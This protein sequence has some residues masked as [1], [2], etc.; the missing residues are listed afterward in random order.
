MSCLRDIVVKKELLHISISNISSG[1][2]SK[3]REKKCFWPPG[4][5]K[6]KRNEIWWE[7]FLRSSYFI[8]FLFWISNHY[9]LIGFKLND[10]M[11]KY[12]RFE[13]WY[14]SKKKKKDMSYVVWELDIRFFYT[15]LLLDNLWT[16]M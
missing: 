12:T 5:E 9:L 13:N 10:V 2:T 3:E 1:G 7:G 11:T 16:S 4:R 6:E 14:F 15:T 8:S